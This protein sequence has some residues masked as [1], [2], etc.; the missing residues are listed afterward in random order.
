[1]AMTKKPPLKKTPKPTGIRR[2]ASRK[3]TRQAFKEA[4]KGTYGNMSEIGRKLGITRQA[5]YD[6]LHRLCNARMKRR[7]ENE[8][9]KVQGLIET[10]IVALLKSRDERIRTDI[11]KWAAERVI[12]ESYNSK[13]KVEISGDPKNPLKTDK[14]LCLEFCVNSIFVKPTPLGICLGT[15]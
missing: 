8:K 13:R 9:A 7:F 15:V 6:Y 2:R 10:N 3:V 12:P 11:T 5:V 1:M 14:R 4:I